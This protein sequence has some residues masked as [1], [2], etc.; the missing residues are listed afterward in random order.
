MG[1]D[2]ERALRAHGPVDRVLLP[3][4]CL[5]EREVFLDDR[6]RSDLE[7]SLGVPVTIGFDE[8]SAH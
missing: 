3:P 6:T 7:R 5:K 4:N 1:E 8:R 2:I